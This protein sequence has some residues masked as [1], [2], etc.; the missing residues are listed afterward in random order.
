MTFEDTCAPFRAYNA[1]NRLPKNAPPFP[2]DKNGYP[3]VQPLE[4]YCRYDVKTPGVLCGHV[5]SR[6]DQLHRHIIQFHK[7]ASTLRPVRKRGPGKDAR[8]EEDAGMYAW[9]RL[10]FLRRLSWSRALISGVVEFF[11]KIMK[12][13]VY[14]ATELSPAEV[15][16]RVKERRA[17]EKAR[18]EE[19]RRKKMQGDGKEVEEGGSS[20]I[21]E[22]ARVEENAQGDHLFKQV[23]LEDDGT[24]I[25][26]TPIEEAPIDGTPIDRTPIE[27]APID[28]TPIDGTPMDDTLIDGTLRTSIDGN[29]IIEA[30]EEPRMMPPTWKG[31][32][33]KARRWLPSNFPGDVGV[34][35]MRL[36][37]QVSVE[38][39]Q[40][41]WRANP[42]VV[43]D[44][45]DLKVEETASGE[46]VEEHHDHRETSLVVDSIESAKPED[47]VLG[48]QHEKREDY[49]GQVVEAIPVVE[50]D[51]GIGL[52]EAQEVQEK[53]MG[54]QEEGDNSLAAAARFLEEM[55]GYSGVMDLI[56]TPSRRIE[57]MD[58]IDDGD[59]D[60]KK[61]VITVE[62]QSPESFAAAIINRSLSPLD[63]DNEIVVTSP[64]FSKTKPFPPKPTGTIQRSSNKSTARAGS[65]VPASQSGDEEMVERSPYFSRTKTFASEPVSKQEVPRKAFDWKQ[66][67]PKPVAAPEPASDE[68]EDNESVDEES[69]DGKDNDNNEDDEE[70]EE[71]SQIKKAKTK[72]FH[73]LATLK[74]QESETQMGLFDLDQKLAE[75]R[76]K[77]ARRE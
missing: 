63:A 43:G 50:R 28:G 42:V 40:G 4:R 29:S 77:R 27:E 25:N 46:R 34:A 12:D 75:V 51:S 73:K 9:R 8:K 17:A 56:Q 67:A 71:I 13:E 26:K 53:H 21:D 37:G 24:P 32:R 39:R 65:R 35:A 36:Q 44:D 23:A 64:Y 10:G 61:P 45:E 5:V 47:E 62:K 72:L 57:P 58:D 55:E 15:K 76:R 41:D 14:D 49:D 19:Y 16:R 31:G 7:I 60:G 33:K 2:I 30:I 11:R 59:V 38:P 3:V 22:R 69:E 68:D 70:D 54:H 48:E 74:R 66:F 20:G 6:T 1:L 52:E 18:T